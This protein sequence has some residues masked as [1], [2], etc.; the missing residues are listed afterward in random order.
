MPRTLSLAAERPQGQTVRGAAAFSSGAGV[1]NQFE[2]RVGSDSPA[3]GSRP[4]TT[5]EPLDL[6][7][8]GRPESVLIFGFMASI[9][10]AGHWRSR[11]TTDEE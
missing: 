7:G 8:L 6:S 5:L 2:Y 9:A 11:H 4:K 3:V 10:P 1:V